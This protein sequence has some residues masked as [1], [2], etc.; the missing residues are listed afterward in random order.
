M[1]RLR[2]ETIPPELEHLFTDVE[3]GR[4]SGAAG[5]SDGLPAYLVVFLVLFGLAFVAALTVIVVSGVRNYRLAKARGYDPLTME[6]EMAAR[7]M[8]SQLMQPATPTDATTA[9]SAMT[10]PSATT[11]ERLAE[12][13]SL[14]DRGVITA[15]ERAAARAKILGG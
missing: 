9:P 6:T 10:A 3:I 7:L 11:E 8:D 13:D 2:A 14:H 15:D 1:T 12:I 5:M 4:T